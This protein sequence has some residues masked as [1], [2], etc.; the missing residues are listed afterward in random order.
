MIPSSPCSLRDLEQRVAVVEVLREGD[1]RHAPVEQRRAAA[2]CA[3]SAAGRRAARRRARAGRRRRRRAAP[4]P[5]C[6][7]EK[8]VRPVGSS[9]QISPSSDG[10]R[11]LHRLDDRLRDLGEAAG[12]VVAR[13]ARRA[14]TRRRG[15]TRARGSRRT[16]PRTSSRRPCGMRVVER[17]EHRPVRRA[18]TASASPS[19]SLRLISS[20]FCSLPSMCAGTSDHVPRSRL[21]CS[22]NGQLAV[23]LLLEQLVRAV[24]PDL[25]RAAA[26]LALR[27]LAVERRVLERMILDVHGERLR[28]GLERHALRHRPRR[29]RA[30]P[31]EPEVVVQAACVVALHDEDRLACRASPSPNGSGV[32]LRVAL[33]AVL[34]ERHGYEALRFAASSCATASRLARRALALLAS[35]RPTGAA[36]PS[37][38]RPRRPRPPAARAAARPSPSSRSRSS[39]WLRYRSW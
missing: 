26:V 16:S 20:Q 13:C 18:G 17:R 25:D 33:A 6:S 35:R 15:R 10:V 2:P 19:S 3:R 31:L 21:P 22:A 24:V 14:C 30:V 9:R 38:R 29:E 4:V 37:G 27:D 34:A 32:C 8:L 7:S 1:R 39:S 28:A 5:C 12:Q 23:R 36:P 11:A